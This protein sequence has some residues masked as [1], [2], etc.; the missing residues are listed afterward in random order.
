MR[1]TPALRNNLRSIRA[2]FER[3]EAQS[4]LNSTFSPYTQ[5][6]LA[7]GLDGPLYGQYTAR[8]CAQ[9]FFRMLTHSRY[10]AAVT[11]VLGWPLITSKL[12]YG[13]IGV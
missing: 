13:K 11:G 6:M 4:F 7:K 3:P 9:C 2:C 5:V 8:K 12:V 1:P 10:G